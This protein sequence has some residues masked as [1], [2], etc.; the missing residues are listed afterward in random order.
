MIVRDAEPGS[1]ARVVHCAERVTVRGV[2][3]TADL[4]KFTV[5]SCDDHIEGLVEVRQLNG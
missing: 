2:F 4:R 5:Y 1:G 3:I